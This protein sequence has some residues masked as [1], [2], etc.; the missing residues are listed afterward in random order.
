MVSSCI[1]HWLIAAPDSP[2]VR[3]AQGVPYA[4]ARCRKCGAER[5]FSLRTVTAWQQ[6]AG[7]AGTASETR[8]STPRVLG[9]Y[10]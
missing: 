9:V 1:H 7:E 6:M 8:L 2:T 5:E 3:H 10:E 4:P